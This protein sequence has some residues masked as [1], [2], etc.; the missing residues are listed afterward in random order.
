MI[1]E[2][3]IESECPDATCWY[4]IT[5]EVTWSLIDNSFD[6]EFGRQIEFGYDIEET[7]ITSFYAYDDEG[8]IVDEFN[9]TEVK[10]KDYTKDKVYKRHIKVIKQLVDDAS[11]ELEP[12]EI[13][14][15]D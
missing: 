5:F 2:Y 7:T 6:H 14:G 10:N 8:E 15:G 13:H 1:L 12:P 9:I 4:D 11:R 3:N